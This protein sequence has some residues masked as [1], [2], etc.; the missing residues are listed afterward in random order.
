M[1]K[2][3]H[4]GSASIDVSRAR[5]Y[6]HRSMVLLSVKYH[7]LQPVFQTVGAIASATSLLNCSVASSV[8]SIEVAVPSRS[9]SRNRQM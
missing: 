9:I 5:L 3:P 7:E 6:G 1:R 4:S 2:C 8:T